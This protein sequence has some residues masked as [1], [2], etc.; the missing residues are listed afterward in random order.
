M[1]EER[2]GKTKT[3]NRGPKCLNPEGPTQPIENF[4]KRKASADGHTYTC[5]VCEK[6]SAK[7]S[8]H[9]RKKMGKL[10]MTPEEHAMKKQ[11]YR[12]YY[13]ENKDRK[14]KYDKQYQQTEAGKKA[15]KE[16]HS[17]RRERIK[18]QKGEPY[19]RWEVI[20]RDSKDGTLLCQVC[21]E[22]IERLR[23]VHVDHIVPIVE[24]GIDELDNVRCVCKT[25]NLSRPKGGEDIVEQSK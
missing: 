15:M 11:F 2:S 22:P 7:A 12:D 21:K 6:A 9:R 1:S 24:G 18:K 19:Q 8:Y 17:R 20:E 14:K 25:C 23:D 13:Q 3:C 10:E 4:N 5:K 16:G